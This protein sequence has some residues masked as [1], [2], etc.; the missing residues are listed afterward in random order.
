MTHRRTRE[1]DME[2]THEIPELYTCFR[3][4]E[5][6]LEMIHARDMGK[7]TLLENVGRNNKTDRFD[8]SHLA[9]TGDKAT[10]T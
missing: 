10:K 6:T 7:D 8:L 4:I 9:M 2:A 1:A 5:K 3:A